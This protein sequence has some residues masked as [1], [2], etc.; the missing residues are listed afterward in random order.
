M[1]SRT[2]FWTFV[3]SVL[4]VASA[5]AQNKKP[6]ALLPDSSSGR[7]T[8]NS[9][10][11]ANSAPVSENYKIGAGD[12]L[13]IHVWKEP[14]LSRTVPVRPDGKIS[15]PL[16][17]EV[18]AEGATVQ[19]LQTKIN[20]AYRSYVNTPEVTVIVQ[21][22]RSQRFNVVGQVQKPGSFVISQPTTVLDA[23]ALVGGFRDFAKTKKIYVLRPNGSGTPQRIAFNYNKVVKGE[24][25]QQNITLQPGD[26][27]VVP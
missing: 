4:L 3:L 7:T 12:V 20:T 26:T 5:V 25:P 9:S 10:A 23:I 11:S 15:M 2:V 22:A 8:T 18:V 6:Q 1:S 24:D 16:I 14:E 17:G 27:V 13:N 19:D 21:E